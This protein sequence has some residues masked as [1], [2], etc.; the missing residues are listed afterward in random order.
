[1]DVAQAACALSGRKHSRH[2]A[3][4]RMVVRKVRKLQVRIAKAVMD[5]KQGRVKALQWLLTHSFCGRLMAVRRVSSNKGRKT[6]GVDG[7]VWSTP[8]QKMHAVTRLR[9][10]GYRPMPLRRV[11]IRKRNGKLRP[12][13]I[14]T[15]RDR[16][17]Q[18]LYALALLPAAEATADRHSYGFRP[19]RGCADAIAQ[20]FNVLSRWYGPQWVLEGDIR[21]CFDNI[22]HQWMMDNIPLDRRMLKAWLGSGYMDGGVFHRTEA[23]TPQGGVISPIL[24]NMVL[25]GLE[26]V[27]FGGTSRRARCRRPHKFNVVRYADDFIITASTEQFLREQVKPAVEAFLRPRGLELSEDK[28]RITHVDEG[29]EFLGQHLRKVRGALTIRPA[30]A[31]VRT[32][33][34]KCKAI[35][36]AHG[37]TNAE[38]IRKLNPVLR[39]WA[40]YHRHIY[41][42]HCF[43]HVDLRIFNLVW[44]WLKRRHCTN[45]KRW[46]AR[47]N[48]CFHRGRNWTLFGKYKTAAGAARTAYLL[49][50]TTL[51][52]I[53]YAKIRADA[54][55]FD[56]KWEEYF[57]K[58]RRSKYLSVIK[59]R[60]KQQPTPCGI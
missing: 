28:T 58:R 32:L 46:R 18:A 22:S 1:M 5:G 35:I 16:A 49:R 8:C 44:N 48:F 39:G 15:I 21:G 42:Y 38:L 50:T 33:V 13:G 60:T 52:T 14:P 43:E 31:S 26:Q 37:G 17:M 34:G 47:S 10:R 53:P 3:F 7:V 23:G 45:G 2:A 54:Q 56:Q 9:R 55:P 20:C 27:C 51:R 29:F 6:P 4:W 12:L 19:R 30:K 59:A 36:K 24:A 25:D 11:Y 40:N 41:A 57:V